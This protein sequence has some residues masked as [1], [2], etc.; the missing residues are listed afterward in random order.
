M[1]LDAEKKEELK[2]M[3]LVSLVLTQA[4]LES[5]EL[6]LEFH[7]PRG[8]AMP[9]FSI[10]EEVSVGDFTGWVWDIQRTESGSERS[11]AVTVAGLVTLLDSIPSGI[12]SYN[13]GDGRDVVPASEILGQCAQAAEAAQMGL[14]IV[15]DVEASVMCVFSSGADSIWSCIS[16]VL[17]WVPNASTRCIGKTL[18]ISGG[19][20]QQG[21]PATAS[22]ALDPGLVAGRLKVGSLVVDLGGVYKKCSRYFN[23]NANYAVLVA[24]V[25][26][27]CPEASVSV[28][29]NVLEFK[30]RVPGSAGNGIAL[31]FLPL[32]THAGEVEFF[33]AGGV[34]NANARYVQLAAAHVPEGVLLK[35]VIACRQ[36]SSGIYTKTARFLGIWERSEDGASWDKLGASVNAVAQVQGVDSVWL[37]AG[38]FALSG[39]EVRL[40]LLEGPED[41]WS[42]DSVLGIRTSPVS[43]GSCIYYN[44]ELPV[45]PQLS[46]FCEGQVLD[47]PPEMSPFSGGEDALEAEPPL[48]P[49]FAWQH[50]TRRNVRRS[51]DHVPPP[52][53]AARGGACFE[54][55]AGASIFQPGAYVYNVPYASSA[56]GSDTSVYVGNGDVRVIIYKGNADRSSGLTS[57]QKWA[58]LCET[59]EWELIKGIAVPKAGADREAAQFWSTVGGFRILQECKNVAFGDPSFEILT[60]SEAYPEDEDDGSSGGGAPST[61]RLSPPITEKSNVPANY[62]EGVVNGTRCFVL[63]E[64]SFPASSD[65]RGNVA[66]LRFCR[67]TVRQ[68]VYLTGDPGVSG[69]EEFFCGS[70]RIKGDMLHYTYLSLETV[71]I[72][73]HRCRYQV[74]TNMPEDAD[75]DADDD[76]GSGDNTAEEE[77]EEPD[78]EESVDYYA[79]LW[80]YYLATRELNEVDT[81]VEF[82]GVEG[83]EPGCVSLDSVLA[84]A[85]LS[86]TAARMTWDA[87][88]HTLTV[89]NSRRDILG[90]DELIQRQQAGRKTAESSVLQRAGSVRSGNLPYGLDY[91][92]PLVMW[93][94]DMGDG[95]EGGDDPGN[96]E[97]D[98]SDGEEEGNEAPMVAP[99]ISANHS[100]SSS[101]RPLAP[102]QLYKDD[103]GSWRLN[104]GILPSPG[105]FIRFEGAD[106]TGKVGKGVTFSVKAKWDSASRTWK[107]RIFRSLRA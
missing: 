71:F 56:M 23:W 101:A 81:E 8:G 3:G 104:G 73:R 21:V 44:S 98:G 89:S 54:I 40:C 26:R 4:S 74:G 2:A 5:D 59:K 82:H 60:A 92:G 105:G 75:D 27:C 20:S 72:N 79:A 107:P 24:N 41:P 76:G 48:S 33:T 62:D 19:R 42:V 57:G 77:A 103:D 84:S 70:K 64:G 22:I 93:Y 52:V 86:A 55:P 47:D 97:G 68:M 34:D 30:A 49:S 91:D 67:G 11:Y 88:A 65:S 58:L 69:A 39:R 12:L 10:M 95:S 87:A 99:S 36:T 106:V 28:A 46:F 29:G 38:D 96:G 83:F 17:R 6:Q 102:F 45:L 85:G 90:V 61:G 31:E 15:S 37:F 51:F 7:V 94:G 100:A 13:A 9:P 35:V 1:I 78:M 25:L 43:D 18:Y 66:G 14:R 32:L 53:V 50:L 16:N 63:M 80:D